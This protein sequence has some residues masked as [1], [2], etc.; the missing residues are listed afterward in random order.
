[1]PWQFVGIYRF[2]S[3]SF[4]VYRTGADSETALYYYRARYYDASDGRLLSEDPDDFASDVNFYRY[5]YKPADPSSLWTPWQKTTRARSQVKLG[6]GL[7]HLLPR[8]SL[9]CV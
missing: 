3:E 9:W 7:L 2:H 8:W 1:M 6:C 4:P 5:V